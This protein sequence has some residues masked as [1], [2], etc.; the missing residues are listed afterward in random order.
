[1]SN[2]ERAETEKDNETDT[3]RETEVLAHVHSPRE[4][5]NSL[6][7]GVELLIHLL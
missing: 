3:E 7:L 5:G 6:N 1:M 4:L 2:S